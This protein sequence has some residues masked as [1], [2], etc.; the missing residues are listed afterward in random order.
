MKHMEKTHFDPLTGE[1]VCLCCARVINTDNETVQ[2]PH[3][4]GTHEYLKKIQHGHPL[5]QHHDRGL[6]TV[7]GPDHDFEGRKVAEPDRIFRLKKWQQ[8]ITTSNTKERRLYD[9]L[10]KHNEIIAYL[11]IPRPI[12]ESSIDIL[13]RMIKA[14]LLKGV[15]HKYVSA[16]VIYWAYRQRNITFSV[17]KMTDRLQIHGRH[18]LK[19]C[20]DADEAL[21]LKPDVEKDSILLAIHNIA[22]VLHL[23]QSILASATRLLDIARKTIP[24]MAGRNPLGMA[25]AILYESQEKK[26]IFL[27]EFAEAAHVTEVTIRNNRRLLD[28]ALEKSTQIAELKTKIAEY[29]RSR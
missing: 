9:H 22:A 14:D 3:A 11:Q 15:S 5:L 4:E 29:R 7:L 8:R 1:T 21:K 12:A 6:N 27:D 20:Q 2:I 19:Y 25:A 26:I 13:R 17:K 28:P 24:E 18:L 23:H 16:V 10:I